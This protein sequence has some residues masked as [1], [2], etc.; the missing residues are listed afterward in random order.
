M[1]MPRLGSWCRVYWQDADTADRW[2]DADEERARTIEI[3]V[4]VYRGLTCDDRKLRLAPTVSVRFDT[5]RIQ[6]SSEIEIPVG[7]VIKLER[8]PTAVLN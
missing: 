8:L 5:E 7:C 6:A 2:Q 4:G 3:S 1:R